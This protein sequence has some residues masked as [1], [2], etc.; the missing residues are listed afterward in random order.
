MGVTLTQLAVIET[1]KQCFY[2]LG[3]DFDC[4]F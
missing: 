1:L 3:I 4:L 2:G